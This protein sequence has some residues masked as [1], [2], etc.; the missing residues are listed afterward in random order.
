MTASL[1]L[2]RT[3]A[4][5]N[6]LDVQQHPPSALILLDNFYMQIPILIFRNRNSIPQGP[7]LPGVEDGW[8]IPEKGEAN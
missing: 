3:L 4:S 1:A 2:Q 8:I 6:I 7:A 5:D